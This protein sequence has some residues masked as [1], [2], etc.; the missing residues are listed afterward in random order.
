MILTKILV[1]IL[2]MCILNVIKEGF[3]FYAAFNSENGHYDSSV[4]RTVLL[5]SSISYIVTIIFCGF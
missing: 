2:V 1:F 4:T 5:F 3:R